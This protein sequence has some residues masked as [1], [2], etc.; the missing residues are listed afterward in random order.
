MKNWTIKLKLSVDETWI[1]DGF[2]A[3]ERL[4]QIEELI[5]QLLPY[6]FA[7]EFRVK[8]S[9]E[10]APKEEDIKRLQGYID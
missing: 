5:T 8:A 1:K 6:A 4:E 3:K 9:I 10:T 2:D 7:N